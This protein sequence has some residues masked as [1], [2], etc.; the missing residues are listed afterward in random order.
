[1]P[2]AGAEAA[3]RAFRARWNATVARSAYGRLGYAGV[4][5]ERYA[6]WG[7]R[8]PRAESEALDAEFGGTARPSAWLLGLVGPCYCWLLG[9]RWMD[10]RYP[11]MDEAEAGRYLLWLT[12]EAAG[13]RVA[14]RGVRDGRG[15]TG[16]ARANGVAGC[17]HKHKRRRSEDGDGEVGG[18]EREAREGHT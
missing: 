15:R 4:R 16:R 1:M 8:L 9:R 18:G 13:R 14:R 6:G 12:S 5:R 11:S 7:T 17:K 3:Y 2:G 10:P